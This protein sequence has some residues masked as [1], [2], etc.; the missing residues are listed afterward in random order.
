MIYSGL[1]DKQT[2]Q[3]ADHT[4]PAMISSPN[5]VTAASRWPWFMM[6]LPWPWAHQNV[7]W[8]PIQAI[9]VATAFPALFPVLFEGAYVLS[10]ELP[11]YYLIK[12]IG[13]HNPTKRFSFWP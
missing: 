5:W 4:R 13:N 1:G 8:N 7:L 10:N 9:R 2:E 11:W 12:M 3:Q 6:I